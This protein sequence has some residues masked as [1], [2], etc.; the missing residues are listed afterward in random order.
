MICGLH[1]LALVTLCSN[2]EETLDSD[3]K[4]VNK[5]ASGEMLA[6]LKRQQLHSGIGRDVPTLTIASKSGTLDH[7]RSDVDI[8][9]TPYG[10]V[11][12][13]MTGRRHSGSF[14]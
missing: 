6:I 4:L 14:L 1:V 10:D 3:G 13:A 12:M 11:A 7:L 2:G 9:Y 5:A 8:L